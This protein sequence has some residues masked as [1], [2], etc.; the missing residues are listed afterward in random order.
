MVCRTVLGLMAAMAG[1]G[2]Q[3]NRCYVSWSRRLLAARLQASLLVGLDLFKLNYL[4]AMKPNG[5][6]GTCWQPGCR[7]ASCLQENPCPEFNPKP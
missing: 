4:T 2:C 5:K 7:H 1:L 3:S 6:P